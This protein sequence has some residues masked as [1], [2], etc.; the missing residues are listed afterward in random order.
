MKKLITFTIF[1][2]VFSAC[3][4]QDP[5]VKMHDWNYTNEWFYRGNERFQVYKTITGNRFIYD[6][7]RDSTE[8]KRTYIKQ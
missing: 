4:S 3:S 6:L 2:L 5:C 7:N 8:F 1:I